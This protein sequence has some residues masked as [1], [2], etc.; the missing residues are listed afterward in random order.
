MKARNQSE[1]CEDRG[2]RHQ[3]LRE[4]EAAIEEQPIA[5]HPLHARGERSLERDEH[6]D[7]QREV[8]QRGVEDH[9]WFFWLA[10][11][12]GLTITAA[13]VAPRYVGAS[14]TCA[15]DGGAVAGAASAPIADSSGTAD[16]AGCGFEHPCTTA[17]VSAPIA[18]AKDPTRKRMCLI[19]CMNRDYGGAWTR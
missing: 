6:R 12:F 4:E 2:R 7:E 10:A 5:E 17:S 16:T 19:S 13:L 3:V 8:D 9:F 15:A 18:N 1:H 11:G 14:S